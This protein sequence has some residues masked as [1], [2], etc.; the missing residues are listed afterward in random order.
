MAEARLYNLCRLYR[1]CLNIQKT[2][3]AKV[4]Q[5][6]ELLKTSS[7]NTHQ[8]M[9]RFT[10]AETRLETNYTEVRKNNVKGENS[11]QI[12]HE[13]NLSSLRTQKRSNGLK[14]S[15]QIQ[16]KAKWKNFHPGSSP[17]RHKNPL[18]KSPPKKARCKTAT[19]DTKCNSVLGYREVKHIEQFP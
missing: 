1:C 13:T 14:D 15:D 4:F 8:G 5:R 10:S 3:D 6:V 9:R 19:V 17:S 16:L 12:L 7:T 18:T 2:L 11:S